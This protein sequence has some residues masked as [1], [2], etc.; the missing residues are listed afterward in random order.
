MLPIDKH[1]RLTEKQGRKLARI[2][3][4]RKCTEAEVLRNLLDEAQV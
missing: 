4:K 1:I 3:K 2:A